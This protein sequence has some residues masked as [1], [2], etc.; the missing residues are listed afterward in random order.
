MKRKKIIFWSVS[1]VVMLYL[2]LA[3]LRFGPKDA[4]AQIC[5]RLKMVSEGGTPPLDVSCGAGWVELNQVQ[6]RPACPPYSN[7]TR[8]V[9]LCITDI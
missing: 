6:G 7:C 5:I 3:N 8:H 1:V 9:A 4:S 2:A